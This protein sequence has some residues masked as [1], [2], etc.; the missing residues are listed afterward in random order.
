MQEPHLST[1]LEPCLP[2]LLEPGLPILLEGTN[3]GGQ[4]LHL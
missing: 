3:R 4:E 1:M 2:S